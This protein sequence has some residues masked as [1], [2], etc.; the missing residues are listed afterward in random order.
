MLPFFIAH[1]WYVEIARTFSAQSSTHQTKSGK[2]E[3]AP[4][5]RT[6]SGLRSWDLNVG[7]DVGVATLLV[8]RVYRG[9]SV[10]VIRAIGDA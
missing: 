6:C 2:H 1:T 10:T 9:R 8:T 4:R 7:N 5:G 3:T